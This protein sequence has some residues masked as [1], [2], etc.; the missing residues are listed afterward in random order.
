MGILTNLIKGMG[1]N[2]KEIKQKFKEAQQEL[3]VQTMI[4]ERSKS[5][6]QRELERYVKEENEKSIKETL[7][8]IHK[9]QNADNWKGQSIL[10]SQKSILHEDTKI[11]ENDR[12]I[13][14]QKN[15]FLDNKL[16]IPL[17]KKKKKLFKGW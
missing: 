17:S 10:K 3:K 5:A 13:L 11:L 12:P 1:E 4:E 14:G 8:K 15:I 2:K 6:N 9:K 7:D 16:D